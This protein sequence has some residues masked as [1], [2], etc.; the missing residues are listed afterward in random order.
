FA[1]LA[2]TRLRVGTQVQGL[3]IR[4]LFPKTGPIHCLS[5]LGRE[6]FL[7]IPFEN[8]HGHI[9]FFLSISGI[10]TAIASGL[11]DSERAFHFHQEILQALFDSVNEILEAVLGVHSESRG[12]EFKPHLQPKFESGAL[13]PLRTDHIQGDVF[14]NISQ[15]FAL[16][17]QDVLLGDPGPN[18]HPD[19]HDALGEVLNMIGG[20]A[21]SHL[22][23]AGDR[24][25]LGVPKAALNRPDLMEMAG[26]HAF[27]S[28]VFTSNYGPFEVCVSI[29]NEP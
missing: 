10:T 21:K 27:L 13:V 9:D 24:Y 4:P 14:L 23:N 3:H 16:H 6:T 2:Q 18:I 8:N 20:A 7:R 5:L 15:K 1:E 28:F 17:L 26:E 11:S 12:V 29:R 22:P 25:R 19:F